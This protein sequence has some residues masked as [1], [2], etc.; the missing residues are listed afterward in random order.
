MLV[1]LLYTFP[2]V[3]LVTTLVQD[4][5]CAS[6][7]R[8][9][10]SHHDATTCCL[11]IFFAWAATIVA[12]DHTRSVKLIEA[13]FR[14]HVDHIGVLSNHNLH[15]LCICYALRC[16]FYQPSIDF[17]LHAR[18]DL[19]RFLIYRCGCYL[20]DG[21]LARL[22][23]SYEFSLPPRRVLFRHAIIYFVEQAAT[24]LAHQGRCCYA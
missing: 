9:L 6:K 16:V 15:T 11:S 22:L 10:L 13:T 21:E 19:W 23:A 24:E 20:R 14:L 18:G 1:E 12:N 2:K 17:F 3:L 7:L 8:L 4:L 5:L